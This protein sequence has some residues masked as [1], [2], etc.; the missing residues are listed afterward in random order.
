MSNLCT[1]T[2]GLEAGT[3][4]SLEPC[5]PENVAYSPVNNRKH[6]LKQGEHEDQQ[7]RLPSGLYMPAVDIHACTHTDEH[8]M[9]TQHHT[10]MHI[11]G[12]YM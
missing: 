8:N 4:E 10:H 3:K 6:H 9:H 7:P 5:W 1:P 12:I 2:R 11:Q